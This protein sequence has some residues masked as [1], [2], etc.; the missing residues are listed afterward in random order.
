MKQLGRPEHTDLP[1]FAYGYFGKDEL[2]W[3]RIR[4]VVVGEPENDT[5]KDWAI[6]AW[7]GLPVLKDAPG[8][9]AKG[10]RVNFSDEKGYDSIGKSEPKSEYRWKELVLLSGITCNALISAKPELVRGD[11]LEDGWTSA[12]DPSLS[13]G[14]AWVRGVVTQVRPRLLENRPWSDDKTDWDSFFQ[15]QGAFMVLWSIV[16]RL[17]VFRSGHFHPISSESAESESTKAEPVDDKDSVMQKIFTLGRV[18]EFQD[19]MRRA[20][21]RLLTVHRTAENTTLK[22]PPRD[23]STTDHDKWAKDT[24]GTWYQLRSNITHRGKTAWSENKKVLFA[25]EDL[26]NTFCYFLQDVI[27]GIEV[28]RRWREVSPPIERSTETGLTDP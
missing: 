26:F 27:K 14:L 9:T 10:W 16:E 1:F 5:L 7:N 20:K 28:Q 22:V 2:A 6:Y 18:P 19:A 15:L 11:P 24:L 12:M 21:P 23:Q 8:Q 25:T 13:H 17:A 4:D 3:P